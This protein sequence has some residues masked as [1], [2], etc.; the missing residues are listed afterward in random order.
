MCRAV[1]PYGKRSRR[2]VRPELSAQ[3]PLGSARPSPS[4]P[5]VG[6]PWRG[7]TR[8]FPQPHAYE[9][10]RKTLLRDQF[11]VFSFQLS[12]SAGAAHPRTII[13]SSCRGNER[14]LARPFEDRKSVV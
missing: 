5:A 14:C 12:A 13:T 11:S 7:R 4:R 9:R 1:T 6:E 3:E 8:F 10:T 2:A